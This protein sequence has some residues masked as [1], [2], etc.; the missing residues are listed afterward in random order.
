M[1]QLGRGDA[2]I[3]RKRLAS[4]P[5]RSLTW[6]QVI[7]RRLERSRLLARDGRLVEVA[8]AV[9]GVQA[10]VQL[11]AELALGMRGDGWTRDDTLAALWERRELVKTWSLR[12]TLH[13]HGADDLPLWIAAS[14][15]VEP[16][17]HD[18]RRLEPFG[19]RREQAEAIL[20]ALLDALD[21]RALGSEQLGE[22]IAAGVGAWATAATG[23][24]QFGRP[25]LRWRQLLGA[26]V[27]RGQLCFG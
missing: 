8:S 24:I 11:A 14:N 25:A 22:E 16:W 12:G 1:F 5:V 7:G 20:Q 19:L 10:Q 2:Q 17:W 4:V 21:G 23:V 15:T 18:E 27:A 9:C 13:L 6:E 26:A 3:G